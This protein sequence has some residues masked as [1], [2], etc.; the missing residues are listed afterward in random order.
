MRQKFLLLGN[1][2]NRMEESSLKE[3]AVKTKIPLELLKKAYGLMC[4]AKSMT[5]L[6]EANKEVTA[7]Y[8]H[9]TS[10]G[11]EAVQI[12]LGLQ[13]LP[14]DILSAYYRDDS[15]LLAIGMQPFELM[16]QLLAKRNDPFSGGRTYYS[17]PSLNRPDMPK[18]PHQ[19][20]ATGMQAIPTTGAAMG[21]Q[22]LEKNN[23]KP[24]NAGLNPIAVCSL[25]DASCTEGEV[26]EALQM[27]SLKQLPILFFIQDN[28]WDISAHAK[29]IRSQDMSE[30]AKGL[31]GIE[32]KSID[33]TDFILSYNTIKE[34]LD[35]I[36]EERRPILLHAKVPLLNHHTSGVRKE[37][38]RD[39]LEEAQ[40]RDPIP[41]LR[42]QL[43]IAGT[44]ALE[45]KSLEEDAKLLVEN[46]YKKALAEEDPK[47]EDLF[48]HEF[49][50]TPVTEEKGIRSPIGKQATVMVDSALFAI[51]ELMTKHPECL[52]YG[53]DVGARLGGV[54]REAATLAQQFG[55]HRVFNT[56][57]QEAF[58]VGS[59]VGM[60]AVGLKPIVE[61]QF[62]DYIWPGLNQLFT[63]VSR[64]CYLSNG[65]WPVSMILRVPIGAY[66]SG[67]PYH[68]SSVESVLA[69]IRG[70]KIA[71]PSTGADLKGLMKA[72]YYDPNPVVILE[73]KGLYWSKIKGT[74]DAK[75]IE[76]DEDYI[77]PFGKARL[78]T[79][80]DEAQVNT[81]KSMCI[82]TY[83]MG[84]YWASAAAKQ[85]K[86]Q[87]EIIDLRTISPVDTDLIFE[88]ARK[89]GKVMVLTEEPVYNGFAQS[90][91]A[92]ISEN[93]F[94]YLDAPV[95]V[96]GAENLPAI[97]LNSTL[98]KTMLPNADKVEAAIK[99]LLNY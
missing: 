47:P 2:T 69:N 10:R 19:S 98:E 88:S 16:L 41:R 38:Y 17:H 37:W 24:D 77:I 65:K 80:A 85:F 70:I 90:I 23:M 79:G 46:D 84:V 25:G 56:P 1:R 29:E 6:Y 60:S 81:G 63:E 27:A 52:V 36:R 87:I 11:H 64:S 35:I 86:G 68:S 22:Y 8:V 4:T 83:G 53:Q 20:S 62:A 26:S 9:A 96:I 73:H 57:I 74:E 32:T 31:K 49:A 15:I 66:G 28:E 92:R 39:D 55:D 67:G 50:P 21:L 72:A 89:H 42:N 95:K 44:D 54:F 13:L 34:C 18:I 14:Q 48:T 51:R 40:K 30:F 3:K 78:V 82:I 5:D 43:I 58:I 94:E 45:I 75:T 76:P 59:T 61:V 33:G 71:Y 99:N 7:K 91:A 12:A 93:C 97:P